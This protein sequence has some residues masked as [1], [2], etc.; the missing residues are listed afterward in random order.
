LGPNLGFLATALEVNTELTVERAAG[1]QGKLKQF[2]Q[3]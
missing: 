2:T 3:V 1:K